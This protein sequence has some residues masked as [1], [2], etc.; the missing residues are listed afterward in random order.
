M[1]Y[2]KGEKKMVDEWKK[3][4]RMGA[5]TMLSFTDF[6]FILSYKLNK[7]LIFLTLLSVF[8][9]GVDGRVV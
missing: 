9:E 3:K 4:G 7:T 8:Y 5:Q 6:Y 1:R 2:K